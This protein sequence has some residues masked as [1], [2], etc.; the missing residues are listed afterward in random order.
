[1]SVRVR[2]ALHLQAHF[3]LDSVRD[4]RY[5]LA[6]HH[7]SESRCLLIGYVMELPSEPNHTAWSPP[8][9]EKS[10]EQTPP[11]VQASVYTL[12]DVISHLRYEL[13]QLHER[14]ERVEARL[15]QTSATSSRPPASASP[16][17]RPRCRT[18]SPAH[19]W[20]SGSK[21]GHPGHRQVL[22]APVTVE[23][24]PPDACGCGSGKFDRLEPS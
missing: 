4:L 1:M 18:G 23:A 15:K 13:H 3:W 9:P 12:H 22:A 14:L 17:K 16:S 20:K 19:P 8:F 5:T 11:A 2:V 10:W 6:S 24:L 7:Q 21:P